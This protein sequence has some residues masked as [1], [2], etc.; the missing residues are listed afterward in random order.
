M[1][2]VEFQPYSACDVRAKWY[3]WLAEIHFGAHPIRAHQSIYRE[4]Q[5]ST[6]GSVVR[7]A[8]SVKPYLA[9]I[10]RI[11]L[12]TAAREV[13]LAMKIRAGVEAQERLDHAHSSG[14]GL[15]KQEQRRLFRIAAVGEEAKEI[16]TTSNLRLVV[17]NAKAYRG[18]GLSLAD[19]IQAGNIGL[20][21]AVEKFDHTKGFRFSTYATAWIKQGIRRAIADQGRTI[22]LPVHLTDQVHRLHSLRREL[23]VELGREAEVEELAA[24]M[25][26]TTDKVEML[27]RVSQD[28]LSLETPV[29]PE[30][31]G[32]LG[33]F[34]ADDHIPSAHEVVATDA[35]RDDLSAVLASLTE[36]E[37]RVIELRFGLN[38]DT[39]RTLDEVGR[40]FGLTR[41]RI[42]QIEHKTMQ[43][44]RASAEAAAL[45]EYLN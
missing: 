19:L 7:D 10:G 4:V 6:R 33:D 11:P 29:G 23:A 12:L 22:R 18:S 45:H 26:T 24:A 9:E 25:D 28:T 14:A 27:L 43:K 35:M 8:D 41:E 31:D 44:L 32:S 34:V 3:K 21:R 5:M 38:D 2:N 39:P 16:L 15:T 40:E 36:R 13:D 30:G 17:K 42:R 20:M 1:Q 37:R